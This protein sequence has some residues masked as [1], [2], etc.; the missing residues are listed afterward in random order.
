LRVV[1]QTKGRAA[2]RFEDTDEFQSWEGLILNL[3]LGGAHAVPRDLQIAEGS[4]AQREEPVA[5]C[6]REVW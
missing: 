2:V 1:N 5:V 3:P 6:S 4:E